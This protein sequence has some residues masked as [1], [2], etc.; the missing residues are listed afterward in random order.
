VSGR[1]AITL[2]VATY[3]RPHLLRSLLPLLEQQAEEVRA[4]GWAVE[5][6]VVDNDPAATAA[7]VVDQAA[8]VAVRYVV[9]SHPGIAAARNRALDEARGSDLLVFIDDDEHPHEGWLRALV[10]TRE[11]AGAAAVAG[12]VISAFDGTLVPWVAAGDFFRRRR[13]ATGT[14]IDVA[15]TNNLL[16]DLAVVRGLGLRFDEAFGLTGGSDT[17]FTRQL[18]AAGHLMVWC[19]EAVVTDRVP[20]ARMTRSWVLRRAFRSGNSLTR[21]DLVLA[22]SG[23]Q[24]LAARW[25]AVRRGAPR[26]AGGAA[27]WAA[28]ALSRRLAPQAKGLRTAARGLGMIAGMAGVAYTEYR[29]P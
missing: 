19:D 16:L 9:E 23:R 2:A 3:Q 26:L 8:G 24:R 7:E 18:T 12:A 28:G 13:P 20:A 22:T 17:L 15:A 1:G 11:R 27:Q 4:E 10:G 14:R 6:L 5:V 21:V 25:R 29:R